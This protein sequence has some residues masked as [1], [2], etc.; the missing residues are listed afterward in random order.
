MR[1]WPNPLTDGLPGRATMPGPG[2]AHRSV[3]KVRAQL[4]GSRTRHAA[5]RRDGA[6]IRWQ[7]FRR[8]SGT[9]GQAPRAERH[10]PERP[11]KSAYILLICKHFL[12]SKN[13]QSNDSPGYTG[14]G[15]GY[16]GDI[17]GII[18]S[19]CG[20]M[21]FRRLLR[22]RRAHT[23]CRNHRVSLP[24]T[25]SLRLRAGTRHQVPRDPLR[26]RCQLDALCGVERQA[27]VPCHAAPLG[28]YRAILFHRVARVGGQVALELRHAR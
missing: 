15:A 23:G 12:R 14:R 27:L 20:L 3:A 21:P 24:R 16:P 22:S 18:H 4:V 13:A 19:L 1:T 26:C 17:N 10:G 5:P 7:V 8:A 28:K 2:C 11:P 6:A 9:L 25:E